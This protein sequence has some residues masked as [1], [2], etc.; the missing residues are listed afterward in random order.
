MTRARFFGVMMVIAA[1][2]CFAAGAAAPKQKKSPSTRPADAKSALLALLDVERQSQAYYRAVLIK[3]RPFHPF[4]MVYHMERQ[5]EQALVDQLKAD[6]F[7]VP[8]DRWQAG[9]ID[10]PESRDDALAQAVA[11][12]KKTILAYDGA[13]KLTTSDDARV[14]LRR[15]REESVDHQQWF[16]NPESCPMPGRGGRGPGRAARAARS[17]DE[18]CPRRRPHVNSVRDLPFSA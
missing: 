11:L 4:G 10:V 7:A 13:I 5:H 3:H 18:P 12:E 9:D 1:I 8:D 16:E 14:T 17:A 2:A 15:L 6:G